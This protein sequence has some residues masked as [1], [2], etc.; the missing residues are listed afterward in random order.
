M[1]ISSNLMSGCSNCAIWTNLFPEN[2][3]QGRRE[4][5]SDYVTVGHGLGPWKTQ[6][7][8]VITVSILCQILTIDPPCSPVRARYVVSFVSVT[9]DLCFT[10]VVV[11]LYA[12]TCCIGP[13][14]DDTWPYM[15][16]FWYGLCLVRLSLKCLD[17]AHN[18][19]S[20]RPNDAYMRR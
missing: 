10:S 19:N 8:F 11:V 20:L 5:L 13:R 6:R 4:L 9:A 3:A 2:Q 18:V 1:Y 16:D 12:I 17:H 14:Y 15:Y 7:G